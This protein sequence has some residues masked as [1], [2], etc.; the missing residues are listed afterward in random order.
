MKI[1]KLNNISQ[2][3][4]SGALIGVFIGDAMGLPVECRSPDF[5]AENFGYLDYFASNSKHPYS[6]VAKSKPG[7]ISDDSQLTLCMM[8][9]LKNVYDI[10][11]IKQNHVEAFLGEWG[12]PLGWGNST[13]KAIKL[14]LEKKEITHIENSAGNGPVIKIAP[15]A[16]YCYGRTI[17]S[18]YKKFT[19]H[20]NASLLQKCFEVSKIT[21]SDDGCVV[22]CYC[23]TKALIRTLQNEMPFDS[24]EISNLFISDAIYAE[25]KQN[26]SAKFSDRLKSILLK[27]I[28]F[29]NEEY[30]AFDLTTQKIS[31]IIC[32][33]KSSYIY[34]SYPL[35]AYCIAKYFK[36]CNFTYAIN[37][38]VNAGA[39]ADSNASMVGSIIGAQVGYSFIPLNMIS[40]VL[41]WKNLL[42]QTKDFCLSI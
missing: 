34:N 11:I 37:E 33:E 19:D 26:F 22:A 6:N 25:Q 31:K 29:E 24:T 9:S 18:K 2:D 7:T 40:Q 16:L 13:K 32:T 15:L 28:N 35:V 41:G 39:D 8:K 4:I 1:Q 20:F 12:A 10:N 3:K 30:S 5:I 36:Y 21:H 38:T 27:K 42:Q 14:I 17:K 23:H